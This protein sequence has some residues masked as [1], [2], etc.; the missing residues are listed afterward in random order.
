MNRIAW[1]VSAAL[2][3]AVFALLAVSP[4]QSA[5]SPPD[6]GSG[7]YVVTGATVWSVRVAGGNTFVT[8]TE[9][10]A[11]TGIATGTFTHDIV[12]TLRADGSLTFRGNGMF[13]GTF[14]GVSGGFTYSLEGQ[15]SVVSA[16]L[17]GTITVL[18]GSGGLA[19]LRAVATID[20]IPATG[21]TYTVQYH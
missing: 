16:N 18:D 7:S 20:G 6:T 15:G 5:A 12:L 14:N 10:A 19:G 8:E 4:G 17:R 13:T 21:G 1:S 9:S 2:V 11:S 3:I